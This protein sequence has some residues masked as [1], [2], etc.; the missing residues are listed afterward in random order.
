MSKAASEPPRIFGMRLFR[1][2]GLP[3]NVIEYRHD[4]GRTYRYM[5]IKNP[6]SIEFSEAPDPN[7]FNPSHTYSPL[8]K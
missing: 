4:D 3:K 1:E 8:T 7:S 6:G 5:L 2:L